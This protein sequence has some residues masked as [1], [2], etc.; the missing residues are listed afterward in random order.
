[1]D[2]LTL[3]MHGFATAMTWEALFFCFVGVTIGMLIGVLPGIGPLA[4][5]AMLLPITFAMDPLTSLIM[6]AG[7]YYGAQYG[8][9]TTAILLNLP[10]ETSSVVTCLD[11]YEMAKKGRAGSAL[12]IAALSSFFAGCV[13]TLFIALLAPSLAAFSMQV[14][15]PEYV[16]LI[17]LGLVASVVLS[18]GSPLKAVA[19]ALLGLLLGTLGTDVTSGET[20]F[21]EDILPLYDG[22]S[23]V[24]LAL[25]L[26]GLA[27]L[28][29][30]LEHPE[31]SGTL[32]GKISRLWPSGDDFRQAWKAVLR[33][34][35]L[36]S[37][38][39][40]LP[41]SGAAVASFTSY[42]VEKR[43]ARDPSRFGYGAVEGVA[44]PEAANNAAA[45]T[46]FIPLLMLGIPG[47]ATMALMM[48]AM[49]MQGIAPGSAIVTTNPTLFWGLIASMWI[50]NLMLLVINL[51]MIGLW[52]KMLSVPYRILFPTILLFSCIG[53]YSLN[54]SSFDVWMLA[55]FAAAGYALR[56]LD[57]DAAPLLIAF[58]L[59]P[60][61]EEH[62]R[63][64]LVVSRG[65]PMIFI[66]RPI[67]LGLIV[68]VAILIVLIVLPSFRAK[69]E[70]AFHE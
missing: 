21:V 20:R 32:V 30:N 11:G 66:E 3:L 61:L 41:G 48:G 9:S 42:V 63:R 55:I 8:G 69:R 67:A 22:L 43:V 58:I 70:E 37:L 23:F 18:R 26:F 52:V 46:S 35:G 39:G 65:S 50:G 13:A 2:T 15:S 16:V 29:S 62:L 5:I 36:G 24:A 12:A 10:G 59:G 44:G 19:M 31:A 6:L 49:M 60:L 38:M 54:A 25:G 45:Q 47:T 64:A 27:E 40:L 51:P 1:M 28:L 68:C 56:K 57:C 34:T 7:I 17:A 53:V 14:R 4:T 33:G